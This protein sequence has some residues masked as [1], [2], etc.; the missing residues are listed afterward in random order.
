M[1]KR[2]I[3][4]YL[5]EI[6]PK[7][8]VVTIIGPRQSG[9]STLA[10]ALFSSYKYVSLETPDDR[11]L[12]EQD[13]R[14]FFE[15]YFGS[16]IIDEVQRVPE[17]LSYI[18]T[19]VDEPKF[20]GQFVLTG[21]HQFLL[22][23]KVTQS[24]AG[25]TVIA[26]LLPFS[27]HEIHTETSEKSS[28]NIDVLMHT[29]GYPRIYD[30]NLP[31]G[32]WL[33]QYHQTYVDRDV[34]ELIKIDQMILFERFLSLCAGRVGQLVNYSTLAN[35]VGVSAPTIQSWFS[36]LQTSFICFFLPPHFQNFSK[37]IIKSPKLY[38]YDTGLL[39]YL[40]KIR[41]S[42]QLAM[43]P[44][45]G[46]IFENW[47]ILEK[48]KS[49]LNQGIEP[50]LYFWRDTHGHEV[51]LIIDQGA[52]LY[53]IEIKSSYTFHSDFLKDLKYFQKLQKTKSKK[54]SEKFQG[55]CFYCGD[56]SFA[57]QGFQFKTWKDVHRP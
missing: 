22:M 10:R 53:P 24:L 27:Y 17:L 2:D 28:E 19:F 12:A 57:F 55:D 25:R 38:F 11:Q 16:V 9:K 54:S 20:S 1:Y 13:P 49:Y 3:S 45:R 47:I 31:A 52:K 35:D 23:E 43:H 26:K 29:G 42:E 48:I 51:D 39:C 5:Q 21:S 37:R 34:R 36:V 32:Q 15:R 50:P 6:G 33:A 7:Y 8:P 46:F 41:T 14:Q 40:L 56:D 44:L 4:Q 18:Q 30:K